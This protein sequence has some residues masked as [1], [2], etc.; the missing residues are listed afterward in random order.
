VRAFTHLGSVTDA[1]LYDNIQVV[2]TGY[3]NDVPV[4]NPR[5][6]AFAT[7]YEFRPVVHCVRR[8]QTKGKVEHPLHYIETS[9]FN[10]RSFESL[11]HLNETADWWLARI[12]K[13]A[14]LANICRCGRARNPEI[15]ST[16]SIGLVIVR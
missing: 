10:G 8:P 6:L 1:C 4:Y 9:L 16:A 14:D 3:E 5:F 12:P 2:V 7:Y 15:Y 11:S 13:V